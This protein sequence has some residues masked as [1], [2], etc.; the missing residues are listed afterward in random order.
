MSAE[1]S[2]YAN[3]NKECLIGVNDVKCAKNLRLK[4]EKWDSEQKLPQGDKFY[5]WVLVSFIFFT[6]NFNSAKTTFDTEYP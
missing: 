5:K 1:H 6:S 4:Y 3:G 2:R